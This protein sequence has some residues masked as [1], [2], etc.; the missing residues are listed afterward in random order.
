MKNQKKIVSKIGGVVLGLSM[1]G[2]FGQSAH[3]E[4]SQDLINS[5][6]NRAFLEYR[7]DFNA[8][9]RRRTTIKV[10]A[11]VGETI[12]LGSSAKDIGSGVIK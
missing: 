3:A 7:T 6:G 12:N 5:G 4:G 8:G 9:I 11:N 2:S 10:Y 1:M